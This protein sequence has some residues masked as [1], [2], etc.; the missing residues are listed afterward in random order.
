MIAVKNTILTLTAACAF[1]LVAQAQNYVP[2]VE[3]TQRQY[4][5]QKM[6]S[7]PDMDQ[8]PVVETGLPSMN[9]PGMDTY[10]G[11]YSQTS[12][13]TEGFATGTS[14]YYES[15]T[16]VSDRASNV[17]SS[18]SSGSMQASTS[19]SDS[20]DDGILGNI[21]D[22]IETNAERVVGEEDGD[23]D[24]K[25]IGKPGNPIIKGVKK[26]VGGTAKTTGKVVKGTAKTTGKVARGTVKTTGK[27]VRGTGKAAVNGTK[28]VGRTAKKAV[29]RDGGD[30]NDMDSDDMNPD[31]NN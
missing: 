23:G 10:Y 28:A 4:N 26:V 5:V 30:S 15:T 6:G 13:L 14:G 7:N 17:S 19:S 21:G 22:V 29:T 27:V 24:E 31:G 20:D 12:P 3:Q 16:R 8:L 25:Y 9:L 18:S 2:S 11:E 1:G